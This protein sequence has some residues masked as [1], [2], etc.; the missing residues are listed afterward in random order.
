M[1]TTVAQEDRVATGNCCMRENSHPI[2]SVEAVAVASVFKA[3]ADSHRIQIVNFLANSA[4]PVCVCDF[5]LNLGL[6]QG[7]VSFHLKKLLAIGLLERG[8]RGTWAYYSLKLKGIN[9]LVDS[10]GTVFDPQ[11]VAS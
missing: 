4:E 9:Q 11:E 1:E 7:T 2:T 6:S 3:F 10:F 5:M 8:E